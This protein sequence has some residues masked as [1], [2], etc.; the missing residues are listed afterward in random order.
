MPRA[1]RKHPGNAEAG[2]KGRSATLQDLYDGRKLTPMFRQYLEIK[3]QVPDAILLFRMGDFFELFFEDAVIAAEI[4][5]LTLTA[6]DKSGAQPIPM[7]GMP[8]HAVRGY[9][10]K[11]LQAGHRVA[12]ADQVEDP[13]QAK[14]IVK[15]ALTEIVTPGTVIDPDTL[16][17][18]AAN[19]LASVVPLAGRFGVAYIDIT[20]GEFACTEIDDE[21]ALAAE[22]DRI[23]PAEVVFLDSMDGTPLMDELKRVLSARWAPA[24]DT[25]TTRSGAEE[26]LRE[27]FGV[28]DLAGLGLAD[29]DVGLRAAGAILWYLRSSRVAALGHVRHLRAYELSAFMVLDESTRRNLELFKTMI[30][31]KRSGSLLGLLDKATTGMGSRRIRAWIGAPLLDPAAIEA[32]LDAVALLVDSPELRSQLKARLDYVAD[33]ERLAGKA[34]AGRANARDLIALRTS[35]GQVPAV[36]QLLDRSDARA[37]S[38]F[39]SLPDLSAVHDDIDRTLLD[40]P[41]IALKEGGLIRSGVHEEL[42]ELIELSREG[43]GAL[44]RLETE[45]RR[46]TGIN[47]LKV[48]YNRVFGYYIEVTRANL[49]SVPEHYIRK[50]TLANAERFYT[51][52]LKAFEAKVLGAEERRCGLEF[53]LFVA[54]RDRVAG[55]G[56]ALASLADRLAEIDALVT[57]AELAVANDYVRPTV[58]DGYRIELT[59]GRHPVIERMGL[60]ERFVPNDVVLDHDTNQLMVVSGPNMAGKSTVM[61]QVALIV[62]MG[63]AG[64]FVPADAAHIGVCDR[65]FTRVGASDNIA[66]GQS[67]FMVEMAETAAILRSATD[68]SLAILDE[69]G[70]GTSTFDGVALAWA[71]A[72]HIAD[73]I[74]CRTMFATHYHELSD[75]ASTREQVANYNI[76]VSEMG[77]KVIFLRR[78]RPGG[79]TRSYGIQ[80]ARLA[81]VPDPVIDRANEVLS[82]LER[83]AEDEVGRPRLARGEGQPDA[84]TGQ[85]SLFA[86]RSRILRDELAK[87]DLDSVTPLEALNILAELKAQAEST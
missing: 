63:Q 5:D 72:E 41:P 85:L 66:R 74:R 11:L 53:D 4:C 39:A 69:I 60:G 17:A 45:E 20:T 44:A 77:G 67:T 84:S 15:R 10:E 48:R 12:L 23:A 30:E 6:R 50:Q 2:S 40:E 26:D 36:D 31:G 56:R 86:D 42:D 57:F 7:A 82:N 24:P 25:A 65:V 46:N 73:V 47:S 80:V 55:E 16:D 78:L 29:L 51:P 76:S 3:E 64:S 13:K 61:R 54:L 68:R 62:L 1:S 27:L 9:V 37:M 21:T 22:L 58:D 70:R 34:C 83:D 49:K 33:V 18:R 79:T 59:A 28:G 19:Y 75:L 71:V 38:A 81:G 32:R 14:G 52:E 87:L 35:L 43:K 8:H